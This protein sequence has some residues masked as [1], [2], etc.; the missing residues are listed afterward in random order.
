MF[1]RIFEIITGYPRTRVG[2]VEWNNLYTY[3]LFRLWE[4]FFGRRCSSKN[5]GDTI[6]RE[7]SACIESHEGV[8]R[9]IELKHYTFESRVVHAEVDF[10]KWLKSLIPKWKVVRIPVLQPA[11]GY[12]RGLQFAPYRFAIAKDTNADINNPSGA[13]VNY[14]TTGTNVFMST[15]VYGNTGDGTLTG[16]LYNDVALTGLTAQTV[17]G[18]TSFFAQVWLLMAPATGTFKFRYTG[19]MGPRFQVNTYSGCSQT[20]QPDAVKNAGFTTASSFSTTITTVADNSWVVATLTYRG[21]G[22]IGN[23]GVTTTDRGGRQQYWDSNGAL[24]PAGSQT[25]S[26]SVTGGSGPLAMACISITPFGATPPATLS[27][28]RFIRH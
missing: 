10:R 20:D 2:D 9:L 1:S 13:G 3:N 14:T 22:T 8:M 11:F 19:T 6:R 15:S 18:S 21:S 17:P 7:T 26:F 12:A 24:T 5:P 27:R 23:T 25:V 4:I 28:R 16:V